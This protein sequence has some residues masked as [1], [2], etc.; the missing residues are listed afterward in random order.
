L[1]FYGQKA[2]NVLEFAKQAQLLNAIE[3]LFNKEPGLE[4]RLWNF[5]GNPMAV[6]LADRLKRNDKRHV[7]IGVDA[8]FEVA[9]QKLHDIAPGAFI[10]LSTEAYMWDLDRSEPLTQQKLGEMLIDPKKNRVRYVLAA[11]EDLA[12]EI[13]AILRVSPIRKRRI[14]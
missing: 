2:R 1:A 4:L 10:A 14:N 9:G 8:I 12:R 11:T 7:M 3:G 13:A 5:A 6:R